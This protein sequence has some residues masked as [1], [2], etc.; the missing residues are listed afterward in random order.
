MK[1]TS[2]LL[3]QGYLERISDLVRVGIYPSRS[4][5]GR[6]AVRDLLKRELWRGR[7]R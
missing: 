4:A 2:V 1:L 6:T 3:P 5:G 7:A